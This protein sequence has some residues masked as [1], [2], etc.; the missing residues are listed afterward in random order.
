MSQAWKHKEEMGPFERVLVSMEGERGY[1]RLK[2]RAENGER[3]A[4][5]ESVEL[6][7]EIVLV[8]GHTMKLNGHHAKVAFTD[9]VEKHIEY[10]ETVLPTVVDITFS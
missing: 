1:E 6:T 3:G 8:D 4:V 10:D 5:S 9:A 7:P 2:V